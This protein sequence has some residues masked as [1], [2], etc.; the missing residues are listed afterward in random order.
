[1]KIETDRLIIRSIQNTDAKPLASLWT[2][3]DVTRYMGGPRNY[4]ELLKSFR[5]DAQ[6]NPPSVFDLWPV[7]EKRTGRL[8]GNCGIIEKNVDGKNE[9]EIIYVLPKS[10]WGKGFATESA[11]S[12]KNYA[13]N[14]LGLE[15]IIALIDNDNLQ[16]EKIANKIGLKYEKDTVRPSG[17]KMRV[18]SCNYISV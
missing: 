3:P 12:L 15:R 8:I 1:M 7:I 4:D 10:V 9:H 18:F 2:D 16:S 17:K 13:F 5:E 11:D 6:V 14:Q